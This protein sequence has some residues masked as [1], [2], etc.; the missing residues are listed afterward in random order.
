M[1]VVKSHLQQWRQLVLNSRSGFEKCFSFFNRH[2]K[3]IGDGRI[4]KYDLQGLAIVASALARIA[5]AGFAASVSNIEREQP[6]LIP[7]GP[8]FRQ[9]GE[10]IAYGV[11]TLYRGP[12]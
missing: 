8:S 6:W 2:V 10:L 3:D 1:N 7:S 11:D 9:V 4:P 12:C 5:L